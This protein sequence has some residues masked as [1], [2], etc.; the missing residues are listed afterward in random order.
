MARFRKKPVVIEAEQCLAGQ[1]IG[2][3]APEGV[4]ADTSSPTGFSIDTL[5][6]KLA[7]GLSRASKVNVIHASLTFLK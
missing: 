3:D 1:T 7:I 4:Y 2:D 5:E 6:G